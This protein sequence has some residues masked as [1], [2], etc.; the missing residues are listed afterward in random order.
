[1][2]LIQDGNKLPI[3]KKS[4]IFC[5]YA[6]IYSSKVMEQLIADSDIELVGVINSTRVLKPQYGH[7]KG[8]FKQIRTSGFRYSSYLFII[9]D[10][11]KLLQ[12]IFSFKKWP[13]RDVHSLAEFHHIPIHDTKDVNN[14]DAVDF[15][16]SV[17]PDFLLGSHFNQLIKQQVLELEAL[18]CIN[19]HPSLLPKY[20]GV[21]P[22]FFAMLDEQEAIGVS[23]HR[24]AE[25]FDTGEILMQRAF[26]VDK[27]KSLI[28]NNCL[29]FQEGIRIALKWI[30]DN[31]K[32]L[33]P[34]STDSLSGNYYSWPTIKD[35]EKFKKTG[36]RLISLSE[37]W[38]QQ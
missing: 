6:S 38:K 26:D 19:I 25:T 34:H 27:S 24:M 5:T 30:K 23:V 9:T 1:M 28:F 17:N 13:L 18:Q 29:L 31:Q 35:I 37:L 21:D 36:K 14:A 20:Q 32:Q 33:L 3:N 22:V 7:I 16:K 12:P 8:V 15:I 10:I 4:V 11:F 2:V